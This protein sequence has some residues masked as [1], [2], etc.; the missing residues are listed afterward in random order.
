MYANNVLKL[1]ALYGHKGEVAPAWDDDIVRGATV[2][3]NGKVH[4][5]ATAEALGVAC[6]PLAEK[7]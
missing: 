1:L 5:A 4:H 2:T 6:E 7:E 3:S